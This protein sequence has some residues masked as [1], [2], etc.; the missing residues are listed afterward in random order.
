LIPSLRS[1]SLYP[2][3]YSSCQ[4]EGF[5]IVE[6]LTVRSAYTQAGKFPGA[7]VLEQN[8][9]GVRVPLFHRAQTPTPIQAQALMISSTVPSPRPP[10][11]QPSTCAPTSRPASCQMSAPC[12]S[13]RRC[14]SWARC[15]MRLWLCRLRTRSCWLRWRI[16]LE[17]KAFR[18]SCEL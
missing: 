14:L 18:S 15:P 7:V 4:L 1:R 16:F 12:A 17:V 11:A 6:K 13:P 8:S 10:Y 2:N 3:P 5:A 9:E